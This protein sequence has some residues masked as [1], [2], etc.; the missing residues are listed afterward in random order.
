MW[1]IPIRNYWD[2]LGK[3]WT[4]HGQANNNADEIGLQRSVSLTRFQASCRHIVGKTFQHCPNRLKKVAYLSPLHTC[5]CVAR[6]YWDWVH[7]WAKDT[8]FPWDARKQLHCLTKGW[9]QFAFGNLQKPT[10]YSLVVF[11]VPSS[12]PKE[13]WHFNMQENHQDKSIS[14]WLV[15]PLFL[16]YENSRYG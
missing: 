8:R 13:I 10:P 3:L 16:A 12:N 1:C 14:L 7:V 11:W 15:A 4:L 6:I 2:R 5:S 9:V